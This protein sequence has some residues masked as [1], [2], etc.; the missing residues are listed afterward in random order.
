MLKKYFLRVLAWIKSGWG[1]ITLV[2]LEQLAQRLPGQIWRRI[3]DFET[4][5]TVWKWAGADVPI[6][7]SIVASPF[8]GIGLVIIG[9]IGLGPVIHSEKGQRYHPLW[10]VAG[11]S[12]FSVSVILLLS[13]ILF[14]QYAASSGTLIARQFWDEQHTER[15]LKAEEIKKIIEVLS[16]IKDHIA[17]FQVASIEPSEAV[18]YAVE[19]IAAFRAAGF[20]VNGRKP[21]DPDAPFPSGARLSSP[22]MRGVFL[23]V[24]P[25][26]PVNDNAK[27]FAS[28][29]A[30]AGFSPQFTAWDGMDADHFIFV[31]GNR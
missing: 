23:G 13:A 30:D 17:D 2:G 15:H 25:R 3:A 5:E 27:L 24:K 7:I 28:K 14:G 31:I 8:F 21:D 4:L 19:F 18:G 11:W 29:L 1:S 12:V 6:L 22:K 26:A 16:P 9:L 20:A 10:A